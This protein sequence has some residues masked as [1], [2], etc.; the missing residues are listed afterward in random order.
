MIRISD[1]M[2]VAYNAVK[3]LCEKVFLKDR[4]KSV[5]QKTDCYIVVDMPSYISNREIDYS[6]SFDYYVTTIGFYI[7]VRDKVTSRHL[8]IIDIVMMDELL[9]HV[10]ALFPIADREKGV[11]IHRPR[12]V[13]S[14]S[15]GDGWHYTLVSARMTTYF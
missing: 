14:N 12:V 4:P 9:K 2:Q 6:G 8:E 15:D 1:Y 5:D 13:V 10:L 3:P 11:K 7:F